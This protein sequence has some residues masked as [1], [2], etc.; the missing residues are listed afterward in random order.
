MLNFC[1]HYISVKVLES[2][3]NIVVVKIIHTFN[4]LSIF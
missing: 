3:G 2:D 1:I 4:F